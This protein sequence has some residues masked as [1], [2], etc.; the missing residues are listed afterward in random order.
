MTNLVALC[1]ATAILVA[2]PGPNVAL[3]VANSLAHGWRKGVATVLGTTVG[4]GLQLAVVTLGF[5]A[6]V[7][8]AA[9]ALHWIR[10][11][12]VVYLVY[13]GVRSWRRRADA[14]PQRAAG[15]AVF[16]HACLIAAANPKT[17]LFTAAFLPQFIPGGGGT[18]QFVAVGGVFLG[19]VLAGD[20][21]WAALASRAREALGRFSHHANRMSGAF[22]L[23]AGLGLALARRD[24]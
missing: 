3:I 21:C 17:L 18:A 7:E 10:W 16:W 9:D 20:L 4:L 12:G 6:V 5:A 19:V 22:L 13:L 11:A 24:G 1:V 15:P 23:A 14:I 2:I 8:L